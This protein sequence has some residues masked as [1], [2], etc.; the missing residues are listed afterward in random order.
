MADNLR[1][2]FRNAWNVFMNQSSTEPVREQVG[3]SSYYRPDRARY[4]RG[5]E[6]S[7]V[8]A[9][10]TR[11]AMDVASIDIHHVRLDNNGRYKEEIDSGLNNC[12]SFEANLDQTGRAFIQDLIMTMLDSGVAAAVPENTDYDPNDSSTYKI[13]TMRV[14]TITEWFPEHVKVRLYNQN[15]GL[16][17]DIILP[18]QNVAI[19]ENPMYS[20]INEP[21][22][23]VQ[24]LIRKLNL[25]DAID[26][27]SSSNKLD[28]I[29]QLPYTVKSDMQKK[30]ADDRLRDIERQLEGTKYGIAYADAT[31]HI[32]QLN[33]S[34]EN[35]L[36]NTIQYLTQMAY[37]QI[38]ITQSILEGTASEQEQLNYTSHTIEPFVS[39]ICNEF[40]RKFISKTARTQGQSIMFFRDPFKLVPVSQIADIA[41]KFTRNEVLV[42]N[43]VRQII[44]FKPSDDPNAD[45]LRNRNISQSSEEIAAKAGM[46]DDG[47][48]TSDQSYDEI[49]DDMN[50]YDDVIGNNNLPTR[51]IRLRDIL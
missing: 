25:L 39:A 12:L 18:K 13:L 15:T 36:L 5:N 42:P 38:G 7:I 26:E 28:L 9:L 22:S 20:V 32:T 46:Y 40:E 21:N 41:D 4:T 8:G 31:E 17:E 29:I 50:D 48:A 6:R 44:G 35:N 34:I 2:R 23:T 27:Q 45:E 43:E 19:V 47:E 49:P 11:I 33:R 51:P 1:T 37:S 10:F 16:K 24:R 14:G 3:M 30:R